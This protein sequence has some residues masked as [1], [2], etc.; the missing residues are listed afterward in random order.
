[1]KRLFFSGCELFGLNA[2][3]RFIHR[4]K[5]KVLLY[6]SISEPGGFFGNAVAPAEFQ[7]QLRHLKSHY[8]VISI[9]AAG[10]F[11]GHRSDRVN[12]LITFDDGFIDNLDVAAKLLNEAGIPAVF[13][14][15]AG[16]MPDGCPPD[17]VVKRLAAGQPAPKECMTLNVDQARALL[18][19]GMAVGSH[20]FQH[21]D[22]RQCSDERGVEDAVQSREEMQRRLGVPVNTFAFPWGRHHVG[23]PTSLLKTYARVFLTSHGFNAPSDR[24]LHRN[25][26]ADLAQMR[27]ACSGSLDFFAQLAR[28][29][30]RM[31][32]F[33]LS[34][35]R[36]HHG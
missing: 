18:G 7:K 27:A 5:V 30:S 3:F 34:M 1:M 24:V 16:C 4:G 23:Q 14:I 29:W 28:P 32:A 35:S 19:L 25:E 26:V 15:I 2:L 36:G 22:Y 21:M 31:R 6:H 12:V 20:G 11:V 9:N 17:F 13:F 33:A 10:E 8:N